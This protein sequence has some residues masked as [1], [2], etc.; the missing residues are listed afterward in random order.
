MWLRMWE[1]S[2]AGDGKNLSRENQQDLVLDVEEKR[3]VSKDT[4]TSKRARTRSHLPVSPS[5][6]TMLQ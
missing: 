2:L 6:N 4:H 1:K 3:G 5:R